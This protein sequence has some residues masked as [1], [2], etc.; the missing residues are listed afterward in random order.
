MNFPCKD[1]PKRYPG[2][3]D[4]CGDYQAAK[5][6]NDRAREAEYTRRSIEAYSIDL[7]RNKRDRMAKRRRDACGSRKI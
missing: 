2:C 4:K 7:I 3:H 1:C 5:I 6:E